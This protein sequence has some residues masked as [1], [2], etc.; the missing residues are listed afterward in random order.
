MKVFFEKMFPKIED[1]IKSDPNIIYFRDDEVEEEISDG[2]Q[3]VGELILKQLKLGG[4][5][6]VF[7]SRCLKFKFVQICQHILPTYF[8]SMACW[9]IK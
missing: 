5:N 1:E 8:R 9:K 4:D 7:V 2:F 3:S 6:V